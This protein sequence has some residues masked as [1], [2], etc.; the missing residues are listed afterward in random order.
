MGSKEKLVLG[1][2]DIRRDWGYAPEYIKSMWSML[3]QD[4]PDEYV[5]ATNEAH[6]IRE[7]AEVAFAQVGLNWTEHTVIDETL[8]RRSDIE[9]I[10]GDSAKAREKLGWDYRLRFDEL[11]G[12]LV[13]EEVSCQKKVS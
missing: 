3:Q 6:S 5:I 10:Y 7:F 8:Y 1:N 4:E 12:I 2:I 13:N 11:I 9:V